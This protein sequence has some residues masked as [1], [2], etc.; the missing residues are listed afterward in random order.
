MKIV[1]IIILT[2]IVSVPASAD[3]TGGLFKLK[4]LTAETWSAE[5]CFNLPVEAV[6]FNRP[7]R[8]LREKAW[9]VND[10]VFELVHLD[11]AAMIQRR[12]GKP[13]DCTVLK[14]QQYTELPEANYFAFSSFSDGGVSVYTGYLL[15]QVLVDG[16]WLDTD[17]KAEYIGRSGE[18]VITREPNHLAEQF[19][20]FGSQGYRDTDGIAAVVDSAI[21]PDITANITETISAVQKLLAQEL[22]FHQ[23]E[24]YMVFITAD[25]DAFEG[26]SIKG[27]TLPNQVLFTLRGKEIIS[28]LRKN[29][30]YLS[31]LTAH[32]VIHLW[33]EEHWFGE[34]GSDRPWIHEGSAE[35]L[36]IET[37]R[38]TGLYDNTQYEQ[39][40]DSAEQEC[41]EYLKKT[42]IHAAPDNNMFDAVY[43]CG[44]FVNRLLGEFLVADDPGEGIIRFWMEMA[45]WNASVRKMPS[46]K[47]LFR[48]LEKTGFSKEQRDLLFS[49]LTA[50]SGQPKEMVANIRQKFR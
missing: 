42:S 7:F 49:F 12:D 9:R 30:G 21:P 17:L 46:E 13:F 32:E 20:Y 37:L 23:K 31:K 40:W 4:R 18:N 39:V 50:T 34:L 28:M 45:E 2:M 36:A 8:D 41:M 11:G 47:L 3:E 10:D 22:Q 26:Y 1:S 29:P 44:A 15:A 25:F 24:P 38:R 48:T 16:D 35:A 5:Y 33:H 43:S 14:L 19:V 27:G 6:R